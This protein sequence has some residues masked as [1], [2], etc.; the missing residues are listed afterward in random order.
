ME[1]TT[2]LKLPY[3]APS[4]AQK[5]VT[6]NEAIRAL[7]ALVQLSAINRSTSLPPE[8]SQEGDRYIIN[9]PAK[10]LWKGREGQIAAWQDGAWAFFSAL[11]GWYVWIEDEKS[12]VVFHQK[13]WIKNEISTNPISRLGIEATADDTNRLSVKSPAALFDHAGAGHQLK[14]NKADDNQTASPAVPVELSGP[15]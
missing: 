12:F 14:I 8:E 7:D 6:H 15:C 4:Q 10:G 13:Q 5:H 1:Q 9:T 2:N 3:I 11:E